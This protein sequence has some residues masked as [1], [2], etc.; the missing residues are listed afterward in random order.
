MY[1]ETYE[2][3]KQEN[4]IKAIQSGKEEGLL[5]LF[6]SNIIIY[7]ENPKHFTKKNYYKKMSNFNKVAKYHINIQKKLY[8]CILGKQKFKIFTYYLK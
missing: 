8:F 5:P 7:I 4:E 2:I 6:T 3:L 1:I